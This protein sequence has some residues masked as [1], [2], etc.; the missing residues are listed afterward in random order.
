MREF[1]DYQCP[2]CGEFSHAMKALREE[3]VSRG[4]VRFVFF[5]IPLTTVHPNA[6]HAAEAARCAGQQE[7]YWA[8]HD[9]LFEN[10][11]EWSSEADPLE[12]FARYAQRI[13]ADAA[14]FR[15]CM[16]SDRTLAAVQRS[17]AMAAQIGVRS[18]PTFLV[19][20]AAFAGSVPYDQV[21]QLVEERLALRSGLQ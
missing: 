6:V 2:A 20:N 9:E 5:D 11:P 19:D 1:A 17:A 7:R 8:M 15:R 4:Q 14:E 12:L 13:G 18:T 3:Y 21:R 16:A 10:Q